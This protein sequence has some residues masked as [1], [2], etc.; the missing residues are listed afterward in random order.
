MNKKIMLFTQLFILLVTIS[1]MGGGSKQEVEIQDKSNPINFVSME[2]AQELAKEK[3][4]VLFF[5]ADW[6]PSCQF[7]HKNFKDNL[8][9]LT[10][11]YLVV[12]NYDTSKDLQKRYG[13]TYQHS[14]VQISPEGESLVKWNGGSTPELLAKIIKEEM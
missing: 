7:A 6:C 14:F 12:V 10:D 4:T 11:L 2:E 5:Y 1:A 13:V 3:P 9:K 8:A